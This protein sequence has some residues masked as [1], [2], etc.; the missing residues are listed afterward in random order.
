MQHRRVRH[1]DPAAAHQRDRPAGAA[2][3]PPRRRGRP[4]RPDEPRPGLRARVRERRL[5]GRAAGR[6]RHRRHPRG[7]RRDS[8]LGRQ[9]LR[10]TAVGQHPG[11]LVPQVA[12]R[13]GRPRHEP[14]GHLEADHR[15]RQLGRRRHGGGAGQQVRGVRRVDQRAD[16]GGRR[17]DPREPRGRR[18]RQ[19]DPGLR[20]RPRGRERHPGPRGL[21]RGPGRPVG[22]QRGH[23]AGLHVRRLPRRVHDELDVRL[24]EL[25]ALRRQRLHEGGVRRP[26]LGALPAH[27]RG[28][29]LRAPGGRHRHRRRGVQQA[30]RLRP[31]GGRLHHLHREPGRARRHR[32][33]DARHPDGVRRR[34]ADEGL[35]PDLLELFRTSVDDGGPRPKSAFYA[36]ISGAIQA[37]WHA[38]SDVDPDS[39]PEKSQAYLQAVLEG[40][41][42]L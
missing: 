2:G 24:Q 25:R 31:G 33:A 36:T 34:R 20:R 32:R 8:A 11:A 1:P 10:R 21:L 39:T 30:P 4:D 28:R 16:R 42:L 35:P 5:A 12:G 22:V 27:R 17:H 29:G 9:D 37:R 26:R 18:G 23:R 13:E 6:H 41:A 14:A 7:H 38:P 40:K 3:P 15:G 19:G